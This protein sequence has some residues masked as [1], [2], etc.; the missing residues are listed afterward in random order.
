M[1]A[2]LFCVYAQR[3][4]HESSL[5]ILRVVGNTFTMWLSHALGPILMMCYF[6]LL[7]SS[8]SYGKQGIWQFGKPIFRTYSKSVWLAAR[9]AVAAW[10]HSHSSLPLSST[11]PAWSNAPS[12]QQRMPPPGA[13]LGPPNCYFDACY[14]SSTGKATYGAILVSQACGFIAAVNGVLPD[15]ISPLSAEALTCKEVL[16]WLKDHGGLVGA[17]SH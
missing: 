16:S 6:W 9:S 15:G 7:Q 13:L 12:M 1:H 10:N 14:N 17:T 3:V 8:I 5:P 2:L 11:S 4:W